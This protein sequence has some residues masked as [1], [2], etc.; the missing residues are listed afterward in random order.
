MMARWAGQWR[1]SLALLTIL[2]FGIWLFPF[3]ASAY[4]LEMGGQMLERANHSNGYPGFDALTK[5]EAHLEAALHWDKHNARAF[6]LL[7]QVHLLQKDP[8]GAAQAL[9]QYTSLHSDNPLGWWELAW[10]FEAM[11]APGQG[12]T[13]INLA[14]Q[15]LKI[16]AETLSTSADTLHCKWKN[17][18]T[19]CDVAWAEWEMPLA[20]ASQ[21]EGLQAQPVPVRRTVLLASSASEIELSVNV[22]LTAT[23]FVFWMG[24]NPEGW[25]LIEDGMTFRVRANDTELFSH[26]LKAQEVRQGWWPGQVDLGAW[27]GKRVNLSLEIATDPADSG[28]GLWAGWG[29]LYLADREKAPYW[30][31]APAERMVA[32]WH[33]SGLVAQDFIRAGNQAREQQQYREALK[34]FQWAVQ[35]GGDWSEIWYYTGLTYKQMQNR[36]SAQVCLQHACDLASSRDACF[37]LGNLYSG[38]GS[39]ERALESYEKAVLNDSGSI[40]RSNLYL[41]IGYIQRN[42]LQSKDLSGAWESYTQALLLNDFTAEAPRSTQVLRADVHLER[43]LILAQ[44]K[45]WEDAVYEY[46]QAINLEP[47]DYWNRVNMAWALWKLGKREQAKE[48]AL[49]SM[50]LRPDWKNAYWLMGVFYESEGNL[51]GA[52]TM[53]RKVLELDPADEQAQN[54]LSTMNSSNAP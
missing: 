6:R 36:T 52:R 24:L 39:W 12:L 41:E 26:Y 28:E 42:Y 21:P 45:R 32:A 4:H 19:P 49:S 47:S 17:A 51:D 53:Y 46:Q 5:A 35:A 34:L 48:M 30:T 8:V 27:A 16:D 37:E 7:S 2:C 9:I 1:I 3:L 18:A 29:D 15:P 44:W 43:G 22:P 23:A 33:L 25:R 13:G 54:A 31:M 14:E 50:E 38:I 10:V 20:P 11:E 40:G